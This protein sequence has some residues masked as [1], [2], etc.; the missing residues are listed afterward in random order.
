MTGMA[1]IGDFPSVNECE[2]VTD[3]GAARRTAKWGGF[4]ASYGFWTL[5]SGG[6]ESLHQARDPILCYVSLLARDAKLG[7]AESAWSPVLGQPSGPTEGQ[8]SPA[9]HW[10]A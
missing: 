4:Q 5:D 10:A 2:L 3:E 7:A 6:H 9:C 8:K 1:F